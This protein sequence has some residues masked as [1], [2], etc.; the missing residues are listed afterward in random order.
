MSC[1]A[2]TIN[3]PTTSA[4]WDSDRQNCLLEITAKARG[5]IIQS[6]TSL[7]TA[8]VM[9]A[10]HIT[11][12]TMSTRRS[13]QELNTTRNRI[14]IGLTL[15]RARPCVNNSIRTNVPGRKR[16]QCLKCLN[17]PH[18]RN[19]IQPFFT[20]NPVQPPSTRSLD[21]CSLDQGNSGHVQPTSGHAQHISGHVQLVCDP[22]TS[23][24][25]GLLRL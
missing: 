1:K 22:T 11:L 8:E 2:T 4:Q 16:A 23:S 3:Q 21:Q 14:N 24:L 20:H 15:P 10:T 12:S 18:V 17:Q 6:S 25:I 13:L 9:M 5:S 19:L 7:A